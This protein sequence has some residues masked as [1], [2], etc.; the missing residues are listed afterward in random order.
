MNTAADVDRSWGALVRQLDVREIPGDHYSLLREPNVEELGRQ[1][2]DILKE[3]KGD[4]HQS[5]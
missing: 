4:S 5:L 2:T 3:S 1:L